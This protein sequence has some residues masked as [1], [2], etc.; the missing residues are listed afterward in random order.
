MDFLTIEKVK[1]HC[2]IEAYSE[3]PEEQRKIDKTIRKSANLA[4]GMVYDYLGKDYFAIMKEYGQI[5]PVILH[6][7]L[8]LTSDMF[9]EKPITPDNLALKILL[10]PYKKKEHNGD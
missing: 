2:R 10:K 9:M 7:A 1:L 5:P 3:D 8:L 4:E 6:A